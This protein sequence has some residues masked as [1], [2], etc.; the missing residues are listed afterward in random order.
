M[1]ARTMHLWTYSRR[2]LTVKEKHEWQGRNPRTGEALVIDPHR[3]VRFRVSELLL[4]RLNRPGNR[5]PEPPKSDPSQLAFP[6]NGQQGGPGDMHT[7][8]APSL[9]AHERGTRRKATIYEKSE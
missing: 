6:I 3:V 2:V 4:A 5:R 7:R 9:F 8:P 1:R